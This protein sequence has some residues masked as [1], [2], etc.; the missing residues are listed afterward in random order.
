MKEL[1]NFPISEAG[2]T[3]YRLDLLLFYHDEWFSEL[4]KAI[5]CDEP[6]NSAYTSENAH[7]QCMFGQ[8]I[9]NDLSPTLK[10]IEIIQDI[11]L[12][13]RNMH[14][15]FNDFY[16]KRVLLKQSAK[17]EYREAVVKRTAFLL[18]VNTL[19]FMIYDYLLQTD[20]LTKTFN[21][22]KLLSTLER[23]RNRISET[24]ELCTVVMADIDHFKKVNDTYGH[25]IGDSVLIHTA[26]VLSSSLRPM[27]L[28]FRYGGEEFLI[29]LPGTDKQSALKILN[30][31]RET[32]E[33]QNISLPDK[34]NISITLSLGAA[35]LTP[36]KEIVYSINQADE[37][38]YKAKNG[39][40][41]QVAWID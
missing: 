14:K 25:A 7:K 9:Y 38:L 34:K 27:D 8:W 37:A 1:Q 31:I 11:E 17:E 5:I 15:K 28:V 13:H 33:K 39:G 35:Y 36:E 23:E 40:R 3:I 30:R 16:R 20:P 41:N 29:Y 18:T 6:E 24:K 32:I 26:S 21:R 4:T 12:I 22:V 2:D 19:Q 10:Q